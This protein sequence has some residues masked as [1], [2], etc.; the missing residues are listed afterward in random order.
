VADVIQDDVQEL[1]LIHGAEGGTD[2]VLELLASRGVSPT[3]FN[4]WGKI[5]LA[6]LRAGQLRGK[7]R[8][9]IVAMPEL[10]QTAGIR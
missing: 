1:R 9:K 7:V 5:D 4:D 10:L 6:E 2:P 8:E 3:S